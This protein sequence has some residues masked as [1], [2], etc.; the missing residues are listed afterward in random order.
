[1]QVSFWSC[2]SADRDFGLHSSTGSSHATFPTVRRREGE[3]AFAD[4]TRASSSGL[5]RIVLVVY[6]SLL[7]GHRPAI[8]GFTREVGTQMSIGEAK[9]LVQARLKKKG[10]SECRWRYLAKSSLEQVEVVARLRPI[11]AYEGANEAKGGAQA[12]FMIQATEEIDVR[13]KR[14]G[15]GR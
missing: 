1:M 6:I 11:P 4:L 7:G 2:L 3:F 15:F 10:T 8:E 9:V 12:A 14:G 5:K 13:M